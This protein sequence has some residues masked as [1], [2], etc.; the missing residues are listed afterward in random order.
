MLL[1]ATKAAASLVVPDVFPTIGAALAVAV[2][3]DTVLVRAGTYP[4][5][6]VLV[7]GVVLHGESPLD[8]PVIDADGGGAVATA[9]S[10]GPATRVETFVLRN[11]AGGTLGGGAALANSMVAFADCVFTANTAS[12]GGGLGADGGSFVVSGCRFEGNSAVQSGGGLAVTGIASPTIE[13]C[14][15]VG[16]S[17]LAGGALAVLN[18]STPA[19][20]G[21]ALDSNQASQGAAVW[22]DFLTG[23]SVS[24]S[25]VVLSATSSG[26]SG[27][28]HFS[29]LSSPTVTACIVAL[30]ASGPGVLVVPGASPTFGCCDVF[31]NAG[32]DAI[33]GVDLGTNLFVDPLFCDPAAHDWT[34]HDTS[35]CLPGGGCPLRGAFG[36][37][38]A[39]V[40]VDEGP[41]PIS[42]GRLKS[43]WRR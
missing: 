3:G 38:C 24:G 27:A 39:S 37:G 36:A 2:A 43:L 42:W 14:T 11:G 21:C 25:S 29:T 31:G 22:W 1:A 20:A 12:N 10:C 32:G 30:S 16:N 41:A 23:G 5:R 40:G 8:R 7:D 18:G 6:V 17:A 13:G 34:L 9:V 4:E 33:G 15:F 26:G 19:I 35:P 28:F